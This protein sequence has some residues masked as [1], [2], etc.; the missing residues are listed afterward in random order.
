L[1]LFGLSPG[2][3]I[4]IMLVAMIVIGPEKLPETAA[5]VGKWIR[6]FRR[7]TTEL[8][9]QF[10]EDNP[11]TEIQRALS[12]TDEPIAQT[13]AYTPL[14]T[15]PASNNVPMVDS[16]TAISQPA[17]PALSPPRRTD[18]FDHPSYYAA[19]D[20]SWAHGALNGYA[21]RFAK[22]GAAGLPPI[23]DEWTH[24]VAVPPPVVEEDLIESIDSAVVP[25]QTDVGMVGEEVISP[26]DSDVVD[27]ELPNGQ[28]ETNG[29]GHLN[30]ITVPEATNSSSA[31]AEVSSE[32]VPVGVTEERSP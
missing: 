26:V 15:T 14:E 5:S 25:E 20:D 22:N 27:A 24:G 6:E 28:P 13:A 7:V 8:T 9:Q 11:F 2:E 30:G 32:G 19:I 4:L 29:V 31:S 21:A 17:P 3:L 1:N 23:A 18:Y 12:F 10:A 16:A